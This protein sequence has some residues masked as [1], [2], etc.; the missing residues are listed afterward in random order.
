MIVQRDEE[1]FM[2]HNLPLPRQTVDRL[3]LVECLPREV[4]ALPLHVVEMQR[5][6]NRCLLTPNTAMHAVDDPLSTRIFSLQPGHRNLP[7][8]FLAKQFTWKTRGMMLRLRCIL[9]QLRKESPMWYPQN[10]NMAIGSRRTVPALPP[11]A[12][13]VSEPTVAPM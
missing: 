8:V 11:A 12:A 5:P 13:V 9:I 7:S 4:Q 1:L 10:G 3:N 6:A 2:V